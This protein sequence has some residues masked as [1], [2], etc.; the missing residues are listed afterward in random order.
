MLQ[1]HRQVVRSKTRIHN[2]D[3]SCKIRTAR[4]AMGID[5]ELQLPRASDIRIEQHQRH[6]SIA[7]GR[8][9]PLKLQVRV[10]SVDRRA[11]HVDHPILVVDVYGR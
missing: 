7:A 11:L 6:R 8:N 10:R 2:I 5:V 3:L 4:R 9:A 1:P